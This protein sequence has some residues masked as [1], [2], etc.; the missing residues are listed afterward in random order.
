MNLFFILSYAALLIVP[1]F[2]PLAI[3]TFTNTSISTGLSII[4]IIGTFVAEFIII[5]VW[6]GRSTSGRYNI[7]DIGFVI[8]GVVLYPYICSLF[9]ADVTYIIH[10]Y[11]LVLAIV[12]I[13]VFRLL[14]K[15][16]SFLSTED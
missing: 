13:L 8:L 6:L 3:E 9:N 12:S 4:S 5:S 2:T 16:A 14:E 11:S 15:L 1:F 7:G 10:I